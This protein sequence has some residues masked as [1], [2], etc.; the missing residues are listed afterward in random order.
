SCVSVF[1][2]LDFTDGSNTKTTTYSPELPCCSITLSSS[3]A[4][5]RDEGSSLAGDRSVS[6]RQE[7]SELTGSVAAGITGAVIWGAATAE[8][9]GLG[10][11]VTVPLAAGAGGLVKFGVKSAMDRILC[12]DEKDRTANKSDLAWG[13]VDGIAGIGASI[14]E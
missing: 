12:L 1:H 13:G 4:R 2:R 5:R 11:A 14:A 6:I 7:V 9:G 3:Y 8:T 10:R